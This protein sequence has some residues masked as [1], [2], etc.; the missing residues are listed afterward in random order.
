MREKE[1][2]KMKTATRAIFVISALLILGLLISG[3]AKEEQTNKDQNIDADADI[4]EIPSNPDEYVDE[5][6]IDENDTVEI[7][8]L[9]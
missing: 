6:I 4:N 5:Q 8:E 3:C 1:E 9:I 7:G 2:D